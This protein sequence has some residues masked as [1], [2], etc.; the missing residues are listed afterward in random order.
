MKTKQYEADVTVVGGGLAGICAA[1][2]AA[3][4]GS[5]VALVQNRPV[6]GGNSSSEIRVWVCGATKH[7]INR[8]AREN[9]IMGELFLE[10]QY[11][12]PDGNPY[13]WDLLLLEKIKA[14]PRIK[15][16]LNTQVYNVTMSDAQTI[17]GVQGY[18]SGSEQ[19]L[20]FSSPLYLDCTGDGIV[21]FL[22]GADFHF[23][24][25]AQE[26]F[27][28]QLAPVVADQDLLGSTLFFY[29][30]DVGHAVKF[31]KP[32]FAKD[33]TQTPIEK[34]RIIKKED[35]GCAYWWIEWGGQLDTIQDNEAIRDELQAVVYGIWDYIKNSGHY[36]AANLT[37]EW[38][39]SVPG[40]RESRR[41][42]GPYVLNENDIE[43]QTEF[44]DQV[45]FG[46][47]SIDIHPASGMYT[48]AAGASDSVPDGL[49]QIP[50][51][52]LY[53]RNIHNLLFA[54]RDISVSHVAL[55]TTRVMATCAIMG[56]AVGTAAAL[57]VQKQ[58]LPQQIYQSHLTA[59]QQLLLKQ[60][61]ALLGIQNQDPADLARIAKIR[62]SSVLTHINTNTPDAK[63]YPLKQDVAFL[64]P[65][66]PKLDTLTLRVNSQAATELSL[67][68][69]N[70]GKP[71]NYL[72][73]KL[74]KH[75]QVSVNEQSD[76]IDVPVHWHP[77]QPQNIFVV[78][79]KNTHVA[80]YLSHQEFQG[81][82]SFVNQPV[83]ELLQPKLHHFVR[84]SSIL[85]WTNQT[86]NRQNFV[87]EVAKTQAFGSQ[88]LVNG[89]V[90]PYAGPNMWV[91]NFNGGPETI[92][93]EWST[94]QHIHEVR[95][96]LNDDV[97]EDLINLHHHRTPF[98]V[99]PELARDLEVSAWQ[100]NHWVSIQKIRNN[101]QRHLII[102]VS[103]LKTDKIQIKFT[104]TNGSTQL[105]CF[106]VRAY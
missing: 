45:A 34:N 81:I 83:Q 23:G 79:H 84:K 10:N 72:P 52:S 16:F 58:L 59:Y 3:R 21:G 41:F 105:S 76:W 40:K 33:I 67:D 11:R 91:T 48:K 1:I 96:T 5:K 8:Y 102:P 7:G 71:Q 2:A 69:Y 32:S 14:E 103:N 100:S 92:E 54:G 12:N 101:R 82:L 22:A 31:I 68:F 51:R 106:E 94:P 87:F 55:G 89:Y 27:N 95:L 64:F 56:E 65:V 50:F 61:A 86:I 13:Y 62:T 17:A 74:I 28:E 25:E 85:E 37:L 19:Y 104:A 78:V 38:V 39:G 15:L 70:T 90:R 20:T 97:N 66:E 30:K 88:K 73:A 49:Y 6:L 29:T 63:V 47:W 44:L 80:L 36:D 26:E 98:P 57:G 42:M 60:D 35:N 53:S 75:V 4:L 46:G 93:L 24:R 99:I 77:E 18:Q 9:G 43:E